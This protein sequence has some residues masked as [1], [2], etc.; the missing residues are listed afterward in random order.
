MSHEEI[1]LTALFILDRDESIFGSDLMFKR[2]LL[3]DEAEVVI[4]EVPQTRSPL[5]QNS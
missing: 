1:I 3:Q 2:A 4:G 5:R